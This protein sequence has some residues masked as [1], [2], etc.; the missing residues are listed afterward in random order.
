[1]TL[2]EWQVNLEQ[3]FATLQRQPDR[4]RRALFALEHGM[5]ESD[6]DALSQAIKYHIAQT[7]PSDRHWLAWVVYAT[8]IGYDFS[9]DEY[10]QTF[11]DRTPGWSMHGDRDWIREAFRKFH[12]GFGGAKP[13]GR[14]AEHF[15]IISWPITHAIIPKDLQR[16]LAEVLYDI[17]GYFDAE[18]LSSPQMLGERIEAYSWRTSSR[19]QNLAEQHLLVGQI[20]SSLLL[21]ENEESSSLILPTTR[22]RIATDLD[23]ERRSR[24]WLSDARQHATAVRLTGLRK[25]S[26]P[27]GELDEKS[28]SCQTDEDEN[29]TKRELRE[30]GIEPRIILRP[31]PNGSWDVRLRI[32]NLSPLLSK[33]PNFKEILVGQRCS[34]A[35][36]RDPRPL[37]R[38]RVLFSEQEVSLVRWPKTGQVLLKFDD[39]VPELDCLLHTECLL[40]PGPTWVFRCA[41]DGSAVEHLTKIL[42]PGNDYVVLSADPLCG[43][44]IGAT[45]VTLVCVG[46]HAIRTS[47]PETIS[48]S[49]SQ[50]I[51]ELGLTTARAVRVWPAGLVPP[52]W[53]GEGACEWLNTDRPC[54]GIAIDFPL[55][56]LVLSLSGPQPA[57][58][59]IPQSEIRNPMFICLGELGQGKY[60]LS[61]FDASQE[62]ATIGTLNLQVRP[63]RAVHHL[64]GFTSPLQLV[65]TPANPTME[66]LWEGSAV[67]EILGPDCHDAEVELLMYRDRNCSALIAE[68]KF[69]PIKLPVSANTFFNT[70]KTAV[71]TQHMQNAYDEASACVLNIRTRELGQQKVRCEREFVPLRWALRHQNQSYFLRIVQLDEER[72]ITVSY[73]S[74]DHPDRE[75]ILNGPQFLAGFQVP[76]N[77]GLYLG[78]SGD[79][80]CSVVIPPR[81]HSLNDLGLGSTCVG[82][83]SAENRL[84]HIFAVFELWSRS[85]LPGDLFAKIRKE[86]VLSMLRNTIVALLCGDKW[87]AIERTLNQDRDLVETFK[88]TISTSPRE[89]YILNQLATKSDDFK[90][91]SI[92]G[93]AKLLV[94]TLHQFAELPAISLAHDHGMSGYQWITEFALRSFGATEGVRLWA[95]DEFAIALTYLRR[96]RLLARTARFVTLMQPSTDNVAH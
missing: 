12:R 64:T 90:W 5:N 31:L 55:A 78:K 74:F 67:V 73:L 85:R 22:R 4:N 72:P 84:D 58:M 96:Q 17:R 61:L 68:R 8:E 82:T 49:Y 34:V 62:R 53:D 81:I 94:R 57:E 42:R 59:V 83:Q 25:G 46:I 6:R 9:G 26:A 1:M 38:G 70:F 16:Q 21:N 50:K 91:L 93:A 19:F 3:H 69:G 65:V 2:N 14:W 24:E 11:S 80:Q 33:F 71:Q 54:I 20:A 18:L 63:P 10:W 28:E 35:G 47:L 7:G 86:Q 36:A 27:V 45:P 88:E 89:N 32:S 30:I 40:R 51:R 56:G 41:S 39:S 75:E 87:A 76:E 66:Q 92:N 13:Y 23:L 37:A 29:S 60:T 77:G 44:G 15:S 52:V 43:T 48:K 95:A 79:H